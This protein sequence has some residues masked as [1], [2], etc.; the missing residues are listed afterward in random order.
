[1][2]IEIFDFK[3]AGGLVLLLIAL[4]ELI[5]GPE[6]EKTLLAQPELFPS[7]FR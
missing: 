4:S 3:I 2:G 6:A 5:G 1:M 7:L